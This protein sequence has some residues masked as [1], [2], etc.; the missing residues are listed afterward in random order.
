[1]GALEGGGGINQEVSIWLSMAAR[2]SKMIVLINNGPNNVASQRTRKDTGQKDS[3]ELGN[4][5]GW[6]GD[7]FK[8]DFHNLE[9]PHLCALKIQL[10][11]LAIAWKYSKL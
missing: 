11:I 8:R 5:F 6:N 7:A 4:N 3:F 10:C 9:K 2:A 1:M